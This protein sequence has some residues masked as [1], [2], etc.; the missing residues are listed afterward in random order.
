MEGET[1]F[2]PIE[3]HHFSCAKLANHAR[4]L[5][6]KQLANQNSERASLRETLW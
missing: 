4:K 1:I 3:N 2:Y 5:F 6:L